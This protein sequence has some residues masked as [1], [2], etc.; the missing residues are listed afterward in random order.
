MPDRSKRVT[1]E[2]GPRSGSQASASSPRAASS[3]IAQGIVDHF[4]TLRQRVAFSRARKRPA[5]PVGVH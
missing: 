2:P 4:W 3:K 5:L 1:L